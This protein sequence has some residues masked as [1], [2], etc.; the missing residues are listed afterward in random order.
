MGP[1][2]DPLGLNSLPLGLHQGSRT[3]QPGCAVVTEGGEA[4]VAKA[5]GLHNPGVRGQVP[6][7]P[8]TPH[9]TLGKTFNFSGPYFP[10]KVPA[11]GSLHP[12]G[13][14]AWLVK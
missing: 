11:M 1:I 7:L 14:S 12:R 6:A 10:T 9:T 2:P 4:L 3:L 5:Q 8:L 13:M